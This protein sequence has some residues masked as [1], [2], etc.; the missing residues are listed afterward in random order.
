MLRK[1]EKKS[2]PQGWPILSLEYG[3]QVLIKRRNRGKT[4]KDEDAVVTA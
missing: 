1:P 2:H 3:K 4:H